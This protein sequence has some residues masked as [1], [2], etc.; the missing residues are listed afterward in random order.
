MHDPDVQIS[1]DYFDGTNAIGEALGGPH[2]SVPE[3]QLECVGSAQSRRIGYARCEDLLGGGQ[4][5]LQPGVSWISLRRVR[6]KLIGP[7][8]ITAGG[9]PIGQPRSPGLSAIEQD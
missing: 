1:A 5:C 8:V 3:G 9:V 6:S 4:R 7:G 2:R